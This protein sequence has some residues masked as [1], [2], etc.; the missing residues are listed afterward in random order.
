MADELI[1]TEQLYQTYRK[2]NWKSIWPRGGD[3]VLLFDLDRDPAE[4]N[5]LSE[6]R[7]D[8]IAEHRSRVEELSTRLGAPD[9]QRRELNEEDLDRLRAL[10]YLDA[11]GAG[12]DAGAKP[13]V[14]QAP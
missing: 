1:T 10:G 6:A 7:A 11:T 4:L 12:G 2:G 8:V 5:D 14:T 13:G 9:A 3:R